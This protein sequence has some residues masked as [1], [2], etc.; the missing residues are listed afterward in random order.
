[1]TQARP[2]VST[3][4]AAAWFAKRRRGVMTLEERAALDAWQREPANATAMAELEQVWAALQ[5]A[6]DHVGGKAEPANQVR[7]PKIAA[8]ALLAFV[9]AVSIGIGV[10]SYSGNHEF[11]TSLDWVDR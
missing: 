2:P 7:A 10:I 4:E 11:W 8:S 9:C 3:E 1:M 6:K 5:I